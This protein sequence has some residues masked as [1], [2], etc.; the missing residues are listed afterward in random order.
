MKGY[1]HKQEL[2]RAFLNACQTWEF[3]NGGCFEDVYGA[4]ADRFWDKLDAGSYRDAWDIVH[5][6]E[7]NYENAG[8]VL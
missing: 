2:G 5:S 7:V 6:I 3:V 4:V 8:G 1:Y